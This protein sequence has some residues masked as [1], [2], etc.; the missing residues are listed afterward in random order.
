MKKTVIALTLLAAAIVGISTTPATAAPKAKIVY[1]DELNLGLSSTG[2][3]RSRK[4]KSVDGRPIKIAGKAFKRGVGTHPPGMIR[5]QLDGKTTKFTAMVGI[6]DET[7]KKGTAEFQIVVKKK[8]IWKSGVI[9]GGQPAKPCEVDLTGI[10]QVDLVVTVGGD[11]Y[12]HDHTDWA[13]AKF[14]VLG[15]KPKTMQAP[16]IKQGRREYTRRWPAADQV[17]NVHSLPAES[18]RDE[19][20]AV[21]RRTGA[22]LEHISR[23]DKA[24]NLTAE[25]SVLERL[26]ASAKKVEIADA[27]G[28]K[29]LM[30]LAVKLRRKIAFSNPLLDFDKILF[31]KRHFNPNSE[32]T[33]NHMCD[34]YFGF[35]AIRGG[36]MFILENAFSDSPKVTN[37]LEKSICSNGRFKGAKL[38]SDGGFLA[39]DLSYD[40]REILFAWTEIAAD[41]KDRLRYRQWTE[42][43]T[44]KIFRVN[45]DGSN[46]RQLTD[47]TTNDFDPCFLPSGRIVF[48]S[49]RRGGYGRCHGRPV[50]SFTLHSMNG[51]GTD[52]VRLSHHETNEW[53]PSVDNNGMIVYTRWDY[54]DRGFNQAHHP[55]LTTPDG[56][57]ARV[58]HGNFAP[59]ART[60]PH[61][62]ITIR[63]IPGSHKLTATAACHHGQ[64][65]GSLVLI[66]PKI[67]DDDA[68]APLKRITP[69]QLFPESEIGVHGPPANYAGPWPLS[70]YFYL[71]VYD[72][73]SRSNAGTANNY[74]IY[75]L[76]AFGNKELLYSDPAISCLDPIPFRPR[77]TPRIVPHQTLLGKPLAAG[78][79][80][81]PIDPKTLPK[82]AEVG[83][84]NV[85]ESLKPFPEGAE[86]K[87]LRIIQILPKTTPY[88]NNP[89]I[90][91]GSQ[92]SAR[93]ILGTV[94]IEKDGS[95]YFNLPI[96]IPVYFQAIDAQGLAVQSMRSATYIQPGEKLICQGCHEPRQ[97][98]RAPMSRFPKA[99]RRKASDIKPEVAGT[100]PFSF[101][102]LVQPVLEKYCIKCHTEEKA[103]DKKKKCPDLSKGNIGRGFFNSYK[104]LRKH[105]F[106]FDNAVYTTPR[107]I[108]GKFGA[109]ASKLYQMLAKG[110][111]KLKLPPEDMHRITLWLDSNS[112][113]FGSYENLE[114]Q[115][116]GEVVQPTME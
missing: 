74:G 88:A 105:A 61:F 98:A 46:L 3:G 80:Y 58:I 30:D 113:F 32:K 86:I 85:L 68:M 1:L 38:T 72:K 78:E 37:V 15:A 115:A 47:G 20:D 96:N 100:K 108:P 91:F 111:N 52:I 66:D 103:K 73:D 2:W 101:P 17:L 25:R 55:W 112:D 44:W 107:T 56:R 62:E 87:E 67:P 11:D 104:N 84:I 21:I 4:N 76:D 79:K 34:Q 110:H 13:D 109:R 57:D 27:D 41:E 22:L 28:R 60:R 10:K 24:P 95:A 35:N 18:D 83:L 40:A 59:S 63:S 116:K 92:K 97:K 82:T 102:I 69:D 26:A 93:A 53:Q 16:G 31:I 5:L 23:M 12:S 33:G 45:S 77:K 54:V 48:I 114:A 71:C 9:K 81:V 90:G 89:A 42:H 36:G 94:P 6:D 8:A 14:E 75:L 64:A 51:D 50:P 43:N 49:E 65:Y 106:F 7:G 70:E 19:L 39:P 29:A 99:M